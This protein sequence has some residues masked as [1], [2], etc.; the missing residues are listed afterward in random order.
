MSER[1]RCKALAKEI[2]EL[3][4]EARAKLKPRDKSKR[5]CDA[6]DGLGMYCSLSTGHNGAHDHFD[7]ILGIT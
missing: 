2:A 4:V 1:E 3:Q 6:V 7:P 5:Q